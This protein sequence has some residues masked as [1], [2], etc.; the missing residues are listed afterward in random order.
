MGS[1]LEVLADKSV[2]GK[3]DVKTLSLTPAPMKREDSS[4]LAWRAST[5]ILQKHLNERNLK[6]AEEIETLKTNVHE[7]QKETNTKAEDIMKLQSECTKW[8]HT[9][10]LLM[11]ERDEKNVTVTSK[12]V[13]DSGFP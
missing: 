5:D 7:L 8:K 9:A 12:V 13:V 1:I 6:E 10:E 4:G 2:G 3:M 11:Q